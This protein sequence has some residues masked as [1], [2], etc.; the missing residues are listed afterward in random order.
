MS[1]GENFER[2]AE[3]AVIGFAGRFPQARNVDAFWQNLREGVESVSFYSEEELLASGVDPATLSNPT[4]VKAG[5]MLEDFNLF[6]A[7]FFGFTSK[8]AEIT[9]PQQRLFLEC[10]WESLEHAGYDP[11]T[12]RGRIGVYAGTSS[13]YYGFRVFAQ[14]GV[15]AAIGDFRII[16]GNDKDFLPTWVSYKL[17]LKGPS[18]AIQTAC[19]TS[20][21]AL[22]LASQSLLNGECDIALAGGVAVRNFRKSG[23]LYQEGGIFSPD[24]HCRAFDTAAAG[25]INGDG[26]GIVVLKRAAEAIA[27]G[28]AIQ[29][30]IKGSAVNND[31]SL[32]VGYTA[33]SVEG[34]AE[35]ISDALAMAGVEADTMSYVETHGTATSLG[36]P[37]EVAALTKAYRAS[38]EKKGF[39]AI[40]SVKTNI[41]HLDAAAGVAGFIKTVLALKYKELPPS[42]N[43]LEPNSKLDLANSPFYVNDTLADWPSNGTLRRAGVSSFGIGGTNAHVILE[44]APQANGSEPSRV[45]QLLLLSAKTASALNAATANLLEHLKRNPDLNLADLAYTLQVGRKSFKY[46]RMLLCD[47][48]AEAIRVLE[49]NDARRVFTGSAEPGERPVTFMFSGQGTQYPDAAFGLY[50]SERVFRELVDYCS[51]LLKPVLGVD[52]REVLYAPREQAEKAAEALAQTSIT[53]PVLFVIEYALARL[54][55]HW[56]VHPQAMIGHSIGEYVAACLAGVFTLE[57][58]LLLV[59][60]RG[61]LMQQLPAGAMLALTLTKEKAQRLLTGNLSLAAVNGLSACVVSGPTEEINALE[62]QLR[63]EGVVARRLRTSHAFHSAMM[64]PI[65][66]SFIEEFKNIRLKLPQSPYISNLSGSWITKTDATDP[67]YWAKHLRQTVR[68]ADGLQELLKEPKRI[69]LEVGPGHA[70][71]M[72]AKQNPA[73]SDEHVVLSSLRVAGEEEQDLA[74]LLKTVGQFWLA[75]GRPNWKSFYA[76]ER[77]QRLNLPT[78]PFERKP[79]WIEFPSNGKP[80][81]TP[82][83]KVQ[84]EDTDQLPTKLTEP[85]FMNTQSAQ[86]IDVTEQ[87]GLTPLP[88]AAIAPQSTRREEIL[89]TLK[90]IVH[91]L[92][93]MEVDRI[94][95]QATFFEAGIDSLLLI[96]ASQA[97]QDKLGIHISFVQLF[98]ELS[99][100]DAVAAYIGEQL[101]PDE[102]VVQ[103]K[104]PVLESAIHEIGPSTIAPPP[105]H[106]EEQITTEQPRQASSGFRPNPVP[107]QSTMASRTRETVAATTLERIV[108]QQL[109][110][111]TQ[112]LEALSRG[113]G[114]G[115]IHVAVE[116][117][118]SAVLQ[119]AADAVFQDPEFEVNGGSG[120]PAGNGS[121]VDEEETPLLQDGKETR[122]IAS[123]VFV[124]FRQS[125]HEPAA[126]LSSRQRKHLD[127]LITR[128]TR[129]TRKSKQHTQAHRRHLADNRN[130]VGFRRLWKEAVYPLIAAR[131][132]G[133]KMWDLDGNEYVDLAM[134]FGVNLFGH[135]PLFIAEA[136][137][138]QLSDGIHIGPQSNLAGEVAE[139]LCELTGLD[140]VTFCN[141]G[142]EAVMTALRLART[143]TRRNKIA[144][145]AGSY[146]GTFDGTLARSINKGGQSLAVPL[147]PGVVPHMIEDVIILDYDQ[148]ESLDILKKNLDELAAVLV[149]PVQSRRP[150]L[151]PREFLHEL[152]RLTE[153]A[154]IALIFDEVITGFRIH[155]GGAQAWFD[156]RADIATYGKVLGGGMPI[157]AVAGKAAFMDAIDGGMWNFQDDSY[158]KG[159]KTFFAGTFCKHPLAMAAALT[160]LKHMKDRGPALQQDLNR[161]TTAF[162]EKLRAHFK[163]QNAPLDAVNCGSLFKIVFQ[164]SVKYQ[165]LFSYHLLENGVYVWEGDTRFLSTAHTDEDLALVFK[166]V[167]VAVKEMCDG[168]FFADGPAP[169]HKVNQMLP[170]TEG[171]KQVWVLAQMGDEVSR[172]YNE[173]LTVELRGPFDLPAMNRALQKVV[174]RH[175]ALRTTF[176]PDGEYQ[177]I[178][179]DMK[180]DLRFVDFSHYDESESDA[181]LAQWLPAETQKPI[182]L[183]NGP[184]MRAC[185][186]KLDE[187]Y[188]H[189]VLTV[190]HIVSDGQSYGVVLREL[191]AF[192]SAEYRG[193]T[194]REMPATIQFGEYARKHEEVRKP[195]NES[196]DDDYWLTRFADGIPILDLPTDLPR[197]PVQT[198]NV[199]RYSTTLDESI[200][201]ELH[202][203]NVQQRSTL[204]ATLLTGFNVLLH[205]I[206]HQ[207]RFIVAVN[208]VEELSLN[209]S[210]F[211]GYRINP[212]ALVS[213]VHDEMSFAK[214]LTAVRRGVFEGYQHQNYSFNKLLKKLN[215]RRDPSR[216]VLASVAFNLDRVGGTVEFDELEVKCYTNPTGAK[217]DIYLNMIETRTNLIVECDYNSDLFEFATIERWMKH[218][219]ILIKAAAADPEQPIGMLPSLPPSSARQLPASAQSAEAD[220]DQLSNLTRYQQLLWMGQKLQP[221]LPTYNLAFA[222]T[223]PLALDH[224]HF[225]KAFQTLV[226]SSDALRTVI[227]EDDGI[228]H[229]HVLPEMPYETEFLDFSQRAGAR[230][231]VERWMRERTQVLFDLGQ[232]LF[233]TVLIKLSD[234]EYIWY[235]KM[236]H[237]ISDAGAFYRVIEVTSDFYQRSVH[238]RLEDVVPLPP[239][240]DFV[241]KEQAYLNSPE[242]HEAEAFWQEMLAEEVEEIAFYGRLPQKSGLTIKRAS[243]ELG[244]ER[245]AKLREI[246]KNP[247]LFIKSNDVTMSNICAA[248]L[249]A[250]LYRI[251]GTRRLAFGAPYHNRHGEAFQKTVGLFMQIIPVRVVVEEEETFA[252]LV[253]KIGNVVRQNGRYREYP[254]GN[255]TQRHTYDVEFNYVNKSYPP[256]NE[257]AVSV[258]WLYPGYAQES[259]AFQVTDFSKS[260]SFTIEFDLHADV[261]DQTQ[262]ERVTGHFLQVIDKFIEDFNQPI[263]SFELLT[264]KERQQILFDFNRTDATF[265]ESQI[266]SE[267]F[268]AQV[269]QLP[270]KCAV[271]EGEQTLTYKQLNA[272]ANILGRHLQ[273]CGVGPDVIVA[274]L[275]E[276]GIN[277]L[278]AVLAIFKAGGA[279]LPLDPFQPAARV[280]QVLEKSGAPLTLVT[281][282]FA[283]A[284]V[285][286][287]DD[288][289]ETVRPSI[290]HLESLLQQSQ[291]DG[292]LPVAAT[293]NNLAYVIYT[294]GSTGV[295]KGAMIEQRGMVNHLYA[296]IRDLGLTLKDIV[297]QTASQC[298]DI[299]VWQ[300]LAPL[301]SGGGVQILDDETT[302]DPVR[303]LDETSRRK[304]TI[305]E[306]VPSLLWAML[307]APIARDGISTG[308]GDPARHF[309]ALRWLLVT[310]EALPPELC[311]EWLREFPRIPLMNAYGPTECSDDVTH[312][313][314]SEPPGP[315]VTHVPIGRPISNTQLYILNA[316]MQAVPVG[317]AGE[318]YV[319]GIGVGRG[320]LKDASQTAERFI[321]HPYS[322]AGGAR[323]YRTGDLGRYLGDGNI[324]YLGR[325]DTQVKVRGYRVELGEIE[326]VLSGQEGVRQCVV[327][328]REDGAAEKQLVAYVVGSGEAKLGVSELRSGLKEQLP[329]YM[330]PA[331][332]VE[333]ESLPLTANGKIDRGGLPAPDFSRRAGKKGYTAPRTRV[334]EQLAE[335]WGQVLRLK[336][337]GIHDN[338]FELGG[339]S[340]LSL[341]IVSRAS[342]AGLALLPRQLFQHKTIAELA[343]VA[344]EVQ[345]S[346][347]EQGEV[348]GAVAV[349]PVQHWF[350]E[351]E[352]KERGHWNQAVLLRVSEAVA[353]GVL[354]AALGAVVRHHDALRLRYREAGGEWQQ[355]HE[356]AAE[357]VPFMEVDLGGLAGRES[358][359]QALAAAVAAA[360]RSLD[361]S[362]GPLLRVLLLRL[363]AEQGTRLLLVIH[364]LV[365]DGVSWRIILEDLQSAYEQVAAGVAVRLPAKSSSLQQW[366]EELV[367]YAASEPARAGA[368]YWLTERWEQAEWGQLPVDEGG[369]ANGME[370]ARAVTV[371]LSAAETQKLLQEVPESYHTEI[372]DVLL[373]A[374]AQVLS[375]WSGRGQVVVE[376]EGH[377]REE[378][379]GEVEVSRTVG[380]FT[381]IYPVLLEVSETGWSR[382]G[383]AAV[384]SGAGRELKSIKEQ[385][386]RV[387]EK[388]IGYGVL[389]YLSGDEGLRERLKRVGRGAQVSFNYLG[390]FDQVVSN[391]PEVSSAQDGGGVGERLLFGVAEES[392]GAQVNMANERR[393]ELEINAM[394]VGGRLQVAWTYSAARYRRQTIE[395]AAEAY[396]RALRALI[397]H[398][399]QVGVSAYTPSDF[400]DFKWDQSDL[401][402]IAAAISKV[403]G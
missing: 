79:Y 168:G 284:L 346:R 103:L 125:R 1:S 28:D 266:F 161:R 114:N 177:Q 338:F 248:L 393:Q 230:E 160:V 397:S 387:P 45:T 96:Q 401:D 400:A 353:G 201:Q 242:G 31:G 113:T 24:G 226:N 323:L 173:S 184:L 244:V 274:L 84:P 246:A 281:D 382:L 194:P 252:S 117:D 29:A 369:G 52:L 89:L 81:L 123:E 139:L 44:E 151:Q 34:Q 308:G 12:Y 67:A 72:L 211:V 344:G 33:P 372:N 250:F 9:D 178:H 291:D 343:A 180:I 273:S 292:N 189:L 255:P 23:Y 8:E 221:D 40:G 261:F 217:I 260:G 224:R 167:T 345:E 356:A 41:G 209:S 314:V 60:A 208:A 296:K 265:P 74:F 14:P 358:Q 298:F 227:R 367:R 324:E 373:T 124:P 232:R 269:A 352:V 370:Q 46:R 350:F 69:L 175:D 111:M 77:R 311:R 90:N 78:Y 152:R 321:P 13:N 364:H 313:V 317:V 158:P 385:L 179:A 278:T 295:P 256:F 142:T 236:H 115:A 7:S 149:E 93:G 166:A 129:R 302:H 289:P 277:F 275:A 172:A 235:L 305:L 4:Y 2:S 110:V 203:L 98:E 64:E 55:A 247:D 392:S 341:Q 106:T 25:T 127:A 10:A 169:E 185:V 39:C 280:R 102:A 131:T 376:L 59:A 164:R 75:G 365:V 384:A 162:V 141:S 270:N 309:P 290:L 159:E 91:D 183:V 240:E 80:T 206:T 258:I 225:Q 342:Q 216:P 378:L 140:R 253:K 245:T 143:V 386:R 375:E 119:P 174:A 307:D 157:G 118:S 234:V 86:E 374:L 251:S 38:T 299:S 20:L 17:N 351:Q 150:E 228:P 100:I 99:T 121:G 394:V 83:V 304:I 85:G 105:A 330:I 268:E 285:S 395:T 239:F 156:V 287:A 133:S 312:Y 335:I 347:A 36:D 220:M 163:E 68:F 82:V 396:L 176:S 3:V 391:G 18:L 47:S 95:S 61:R 94:D 71:S 361:L 231:E 188:H 135:S 132:A 327:V 22:H 329:E 97:I 186:V 5:V 73:R 354:K 138:Q 199:A 368:E 171:Q 37:I 223:I 300:F 137:Q 213:E 181:R 257:T 130:S 222:I 241:Q 146:H 339:D 301:L 366:A 42:L 381:T 272:R 379:F 362:A 148:P 101:P 200:G 30:F 349:T 205:Q 204:F 43:F 271:V 243:C 197:P 126:V 108:E 104:T 332:F 390:Q 326:A 112:Q 35:V 193:T 63:E 15:A 310:G 229:R 303:L 202:K 388:G 88:Q 389:R 76:D 334:E 192:Y 87:G 348:E 16:I 6:D 380:W 306:T 355:Y 383:E 11:E 116:T 145:F 120:D 294:S 283:A 62:H 325:A 254:V 27:D 267:L 316:R 286:A 53:Q 360:H 107:Q 315:E 377:G 128:Y 263:D 92:T 262:Q 190:H 297:A 402:D 233:E 195:V 155:P 191:G 318:L 293:S 357:Q 136:L 134:G 337:V 237:I 322:G 32:K 288:M 333:L 238:G 50:Q 215:V 170:L 144:L 363:G 26:V 207:D 336:E 328:V 153:Q 198:F 19:S 264:S 282:E 56:G 398:C 66:K 359:R 340:I 65:L 279:Y 218:L 371:A 154:G 219:I 57:E 58:G 331:A 259:M 51:D 48:T 54:W 399:L 319:G 165:E 196:S 109:Q 210:D 212:L 122:Q 21:V 249:C 403:E 182:D 320:Y 147:A 49:I 276:R 214:Y 187:R 70:L